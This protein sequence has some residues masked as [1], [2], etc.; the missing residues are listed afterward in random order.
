MWWIQA[1]APISPGNSGGGLFDAEG[2]LVG[3]CSRAAGGRAQ[4]LNFWVHVM[5]VQALLGQQP[6]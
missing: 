4:A 6:S 3:V 1:T 5:Y 2:D